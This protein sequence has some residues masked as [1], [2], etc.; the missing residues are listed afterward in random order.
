[1][2]ILQCQIYL[3]NLT[4]AEVQALSNAGLSIVAIWENGYPTFTTWNIK[5][6]ATTT[7]L[8]MNADPD[9]GASVIG[10]FTA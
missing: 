7:I 3:K 5:Q 8:G 6:G 2:Q 1:M 4:L 9:T 10:G